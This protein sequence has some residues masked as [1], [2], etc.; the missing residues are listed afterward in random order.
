MRLFTDLDEYKKGVIMIRTGHRFVSYHRSKCE[1]DFPMLPDGGLDLKFVKLW[2]GIK[3]SKVRFAAHLASQSYVECVFKV[4]DPMRW[5]Q[6]TPEDVLSPL[7]VNILSEGT[8]DIHI[9]CKPTY[10]LLPV[11]SF[12]M[13]RLLTLKL[14]LFPLTKQTT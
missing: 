8:N 3:D 5:T 12:I 2:W 1:A 14:A 7:A 6:F 9:L 13:I 11:P 10:L 4:I